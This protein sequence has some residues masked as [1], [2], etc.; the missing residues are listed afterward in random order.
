MKGYEV[1]VDGLNARVGPG[2]KF[3]S[4]GEMEKGTLLV[5]PVGWVPFI[6]ADDSIAWVSEKYVK[7]VEVTFDEPAEIIK[8]IV[9]LAEDQKGD[10]YVFGAEVSKSDPN[11]KKFDCSEL[12]EWVC[13]RHDVEPVMPDGAIYQYEHCRK[14][15]TTITV[16]KAIKTYGALL[17]RISSSGNHVAISRGDGTTIEAKGKAFGVGIFSAEG[18]GW[19]HAGL[20]PGVKYGA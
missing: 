6:A 10:A 19:T 1:Q 14:H 15:G 2:V 9:K 12:V 13:A 3:K 18:R 17:F 20:I 11:P 8:S 16:A 7:E 5:A 4:L